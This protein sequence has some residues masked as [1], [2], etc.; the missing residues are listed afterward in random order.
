V[1]V[2]IES[3]IIEHEGWI[4]S[5]VFY[6]PILTRNSSVGVKAQRFGQHANQ[7]TRTSRKSKVWEM[8][9]QSK[10]IMEFIRKCPSP[11]SKV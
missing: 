1:E 7:S 4:G 8:V 2:L 6:V 10:T 3:K 9:N 11:T 5:S